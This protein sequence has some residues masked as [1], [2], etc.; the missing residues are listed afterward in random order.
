LLSEAGHPN[1]LQ[2]TLLAS[3]AAA[4]MMDEAIVFAESVAGAGFDIQVK[5][6]PAETYWDQVWLVEPFYV[7]NWNRRHAW[8]F[9]TELFRTNAPWN[10]SKIKVPQ[11]DQL[12]DE[13]ARTPDLELQRE[14]IWEALAIVRDQAG[15]IVPGWVHQIFLA[16][17]EVT[18]IEFGVLAGLDL[19]RASLA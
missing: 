9:L 10:E 15:W 18:G 14:P 16:K 11:I 1:G 2:L 3:E 8:Q 17:K 4:A 19:R 7:S 12:L 6:V 13:A 5:Q